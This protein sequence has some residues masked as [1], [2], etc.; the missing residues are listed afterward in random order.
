MEPLNT[1]QLKVM[2]KYLWATYKLTNLSFIRNITLGIL[3]EST[4]AWEGIG[5]ETI[6]S[7]WAIYLCMK[8]F[9]SRF[10]VRR[11]HMQMPTNRWVVNV[12]V[13]ILQIWIGRHYG[14]SLDTVQTLYCS[15][16]WLYDTVQTLYL[17]LYH[18][19]VQRLSKVGL[20]KA[21]CWLL[22]KS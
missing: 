15:D 2:E 19:I 3:H 22:I 5:C 6:Y 12:N 10:R 20:K 13:C 18:H 11:N 8:W 4:S 7:S 16:L 17:T 14:T 9:C 21:L 1:L